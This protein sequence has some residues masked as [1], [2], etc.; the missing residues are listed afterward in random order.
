MYAHEDFKGRVEPAHVHER[1]SDP[2]LP[3][4][5][6]RAMR[7]ILAGGRAP[8]WQRAVQAVMAMAKRRAEA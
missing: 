7:A 6:N 3:A 4:S 1:R 5:R 2:P 8:W